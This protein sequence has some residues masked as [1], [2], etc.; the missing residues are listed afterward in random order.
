MRILAKIVKFSLLNTITL[1]LVC[2]ININSAYAENNSFAPGTLI[3]TSNGNIP[4][5]ELH[6]GDRTV[7]KSKRSH[8][9]MT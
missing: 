9:S 2:F 5:E 4:I 1:L 7:L 6:S 3:L 8:M